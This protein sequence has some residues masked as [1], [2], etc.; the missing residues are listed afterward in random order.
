MHKWAKSRHFLSCGEGGGW[1]SLFC[2]LSYWLR[3][4]MA[5]LRRG[6]DQRDTAHDQRTIFKRFT[7]NYKNLTS[8]FPCWNIVRVKTLAM[9]ISEWYT[10]LLN[11]DS[12]ILL[13]RLLWFVIITLFY[14]WL[15][16]E[17]KMSID[18]FFSYPVVTVVIINHVPEVYFP[19][20]TICNQNMIKADNAE[21]HKIFLE[22]SEKCFYLYIYYLV[23]VFYIS[24][25]LNCSNL[26]ITWFI[27]FC[28]FISW[29]NDISF[30][31]VV[32]TI[33][34]DDFILY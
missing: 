32:Q 21:N 4:A 11:C 6:T 30:K 5:V 27:F 26:I 2:G 17:L 16:L 12:N 15:I 3:K 1:G 23:F 10:F 34:R 19:A 25:W 24:L 18:K 28:L 13:F 14:S 7:C 9:L 20:I 22:V 33:F 8:P 29:F 31:F